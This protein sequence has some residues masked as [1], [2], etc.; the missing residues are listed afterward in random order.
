VED[1]LLSLTRELLPASTAAGWNEDWAHELC[2][3]TLNRLENH[4]AGFPDKHEIVVFP[5]QETWDERMCFA[6]QNND[7][8]AFRAALK[9]W[10]QAGLEAIER[11]R[12]KGGVA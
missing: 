10:E 12:V 4:Y 1:A 6:G 9:R 2:K 7:P 11:A 3:D 5:A 8:A